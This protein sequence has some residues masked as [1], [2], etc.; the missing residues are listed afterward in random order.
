MILASWKTIAWLVRRADVVLEVVDARDPMATRSRRLERLV[1]ALG[2]KLIIVINK[3]DLVPREVAEKWKRLFEDMGYTAVYMAARE[4]MG[5][6][7]LRVAIKRAVE[8]RPIIVAVTGFPKTGKSTVIN[9]LK[10]KHAASTSPIPGSPGYTRHVQLYRIGQSMYML[11]SP[12]VIPVEGGS[13]EAVIRGK[14]PEQLKDPVNPAIELLK[15]ALRYNPRAVVDAY[16]IEETDP[17]RILELIAIKRGWRYKT[18]GEPNIDE[19]ARQV[20]RDY[21]EA[22]L[23]FYVPPE[24]YMR[25][26]KSETKEEVWL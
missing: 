23:N 12:G 1:E 20:I 14:P 19:A 26:L 4:H 9:A 16:G 21:H 25:K 22:K 13:L 3:S 17:L 2:K 18:T 10:G 5:T 6:R 24:E 7:K 15:K 11:D 8:A